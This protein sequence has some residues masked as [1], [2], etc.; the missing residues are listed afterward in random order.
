MALKNGQSKVLF[1]HIFSSSFHKN[2]L[3]I[4]IWDVKDLFYFGI[5][6]STV[7]GGDSFDICHL[8]IMEMFVFC[9]SSSPPH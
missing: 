3:L 2:R 9:F 4:W 1:F 5:D 8:L 6:F 7:Y